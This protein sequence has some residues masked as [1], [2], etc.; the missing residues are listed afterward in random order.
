MK[1]ITFEGPF[2]ARSAIR[3]FEAIRDT[4]GPVELDLRRLTCFQN[5]ALRALADTMAFARGLEKLVIRG[6]G[7]LQRRILEYLG[8][9]P[10]EFEPKPPTPMP[11]SQFIPKGERAMAA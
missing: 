5:S 2:T 4:K 6:L 10:D 1:T 8:A 7:E 11:S 9:R 3:A